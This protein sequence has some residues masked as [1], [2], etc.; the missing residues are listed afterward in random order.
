MFDFVG[1][2]GSFLEG[3]V[4]VL[5]FVRLVGRRGVFGKDFMG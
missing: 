4:R 3:F 5:A 2:V 1:K